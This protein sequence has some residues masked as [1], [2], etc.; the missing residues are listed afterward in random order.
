MK[1]INMKNIYHKIYKQI[2]IRHQ[3]NEIIN[4]FTVADH[5]RLYTDIKGIKNHEID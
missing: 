5:F 4:N 1:Y 3:S 2:S